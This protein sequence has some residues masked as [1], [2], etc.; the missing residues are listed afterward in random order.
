[1]G[2]P[3]NRAI[4]PWSLG[5]ANQ[6]TSQH[7]RTSPVRALSYPRRQ[8]VRRIRCALQDAALGLGA[9]LMAAVA[10]P[11]G[12]TLV[13]VALV[14]T[15]VALSIRSRRW[16]RLARRSRIGAL[17]EERVR[18]RLAVLE[19]EGWRIR[20]SLRWRGGGDID[21]VA[22][23]PGSGAMAFAIETKTRSY[24]LHDLERIIEVARCLRRRRT[25]WYREG[26]VPVLCLAG[27][28]GVERWEAGVAI[29]SPDRLVTVLRRLAGTTARP[30]FLR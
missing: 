16:L 30:G 12:M 23:A 19:R 1:M 29:V 2:A 8:Q 27:T 11:A 25:R 24:Q 13:A 17:S 15:G 18:G 3:G 21:H 20:H 5:F 26:G 9:V 22:I 7:A 28:R 10:A 6:G 4:H 14:T